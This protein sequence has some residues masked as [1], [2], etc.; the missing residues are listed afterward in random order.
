MTDIKYKIVKHI[1]VLSEGKDGW[2]K[3]LNLISWNDAEPK[4]DIRDWNSDHTKMGKGI[5]LSEDEV[6]NLLELFGFKEENAERPLTKD[7]KRMNESKRRRETGVH[8][9]RTSRSLQLFEDDIIDKVLDEKT[10]EDLGETKDIVAF[11]AATESAVEPGMEFEMRVYLY[12]ESDSEIIDQMIARSF[13]NPIQDSPGMAQINRN[14]QVRIYLQATDGIEIDEPWQ[15]CIWNGVPTSCVFDISVPEDFSEKRIKLKGRVY[16]GDIVLTD[17]RL[18][19]KPEQSNDNCEITKQSFK[20]AFVSYSS[21]DRSKV[22]ARIQGMEAAAP[23]IDLFIDVKDLH[24]GEHWEERLYNEILKRDLFYLFWSNNAA[25]SEWV[26]KE[27]KF[28][29]ENKSS[30]CIEPIALESPDICPPPKELEH[31]HFNSW[32]LFYEKQKL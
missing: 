27:L 17:I 32:T 20:S 3:E 18:T 26:Q 24:S 2:R 10:K 21:K 22:T 30:E 19:I 9:S 6:Q 1:G 8:Q 25:D 15:T 28:A 31:K 4:Y 12:K 5:T 11:R 14:Q 16:L 23:D 13:D 29:L 7:R